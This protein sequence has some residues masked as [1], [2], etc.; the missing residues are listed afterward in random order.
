LVLGLFAAGFFLGVGWLL[1]GT[2]PSHGDEHQA[3]VPWPTK[4]KRKINGR[5][6]PKALN[7]EQLAAKEKQAY[8]AKGI[9]M[10]D[11]EG[12]DREG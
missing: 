10:T 2:L 5:H 6:V 7:E 11:Q 12:A 9:P 3:N 1:R 4:T 8:A